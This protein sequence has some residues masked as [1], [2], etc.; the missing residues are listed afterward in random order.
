MMTPLPLPSIPSSPISSSLNAMT[1]RDG[2]SEVYCNY[3]CDIS[4]LLGVAIFDS[5]GL[6][7]EYFITP[8]NRD[9]AWVQLVFQSLGLRALLTSVLT[10]GEFSYTIVQTKAE[11]AIVVRTKDRFIAFLVKRIRPNTPA[12]VDQAWIEWACGFEAE[13]LR[14]HSHFKAS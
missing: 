4:T 9:T 11:D 13:Q 14:S 2:T 12:R 6:P 3:D 7:K 1:Q 10:L 5:S 8:E